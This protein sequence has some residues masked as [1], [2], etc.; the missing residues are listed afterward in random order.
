MERGAPIS[1]PQTAGRIISGSIL[2]AR[3]LGG[4]ILDDPDYLIKV[5]A[6]ENQVVTAMLFELILAAAVIGIS[7][8]M[9]PILR[10]HNEG[11]A[12][13]YVGF[14]IMEAVTITIGA[15]S[16]LTLLTIS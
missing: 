15:I 12:L 1:L 2:S 8:M 10:N 7:V 9:F 6:N 4:F 14:R 5:S 11:L 3:A 13:G 16:I